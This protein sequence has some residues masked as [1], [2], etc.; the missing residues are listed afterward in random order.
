MNDMWFKD[1][2]QYSPQDQVS[3]PPSCIKAGVNFQ[4]LDDTSRTGRATSCFKK[5]A[6]PIPYE[7]YYI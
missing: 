5:K 7:Q 4:L 2:I 1:N 3:F 6:H